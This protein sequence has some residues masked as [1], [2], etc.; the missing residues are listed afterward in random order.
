MASL[1]IGRRQASLEGFELVQKQ[2]EY[3][4]RLRDAIDNYPLL[5]KYMHC[6]STAELI[7]AKFRASGIDQPVRAA[8][9]LQR[10]SCRRH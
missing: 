6:L 3:A 9:G 5:A 4:M 10:V 2:L 8:A 1:G 7:P